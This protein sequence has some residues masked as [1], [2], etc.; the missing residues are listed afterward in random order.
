MFQ[1]FRSCQ[2]RKANLSVCFLGEVTARQFCFEIFFFNSGSLWHEEVHFVY[3]SLDFRGESLP[4][5]LQELGPD[6]M[7]TMAASRSSFAEPDETG[8][9]PYIAPTIDSLH[10]NSLLINYL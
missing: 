10:G 9:I 7:P 3:I 8:E 6:E 5:G 2:D 4:S 1:V